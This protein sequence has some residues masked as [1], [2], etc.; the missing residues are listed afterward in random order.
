MLVAGTSATVYPAAEFP[1]EIL[2]RGGSVIE[3][4]PDPTDLSPVATLSL[5]GPGAAVL[6]RL[7][8]HVLRRVGEDAS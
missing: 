3:I 2:R 5:Q 6:E 4:N 8:Y 1:Y 7:L